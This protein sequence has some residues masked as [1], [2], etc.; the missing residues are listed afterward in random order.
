MVPIKYN[1]PFY[2]GQSNF[3]HYKLYI[4]FDKLRCLPLLTLSA[5]SFFKITD[6]QVKE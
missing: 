2:R 4:I 1:I 5:I 3:F 6:F